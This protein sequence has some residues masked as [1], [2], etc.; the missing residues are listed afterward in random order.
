MKQAFKVECT[1]SFEFHSKL[2]CVCACEASERV[3]LVKSIKINPLTN[4]MVSSGMIAYTQRRTHWQI[5]ESVRACV[6]SI[7]W[8]ITKHNI[9]QRIA[10]V[11]RRFGDYMS[12][13][14]IIK[15]KLNIFPLIS[16]LC[17]HSVSECSNFYFLH[18]WIP[19]SHFRWHLDMWTPGV[20]VYF[21]VF[22]MEPNEI[23]FELWFKS[24]MMCMVLEWAAV[25]F[26]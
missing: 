17:G 24:P 5:K 19:H 3:K 4:F 2:V 11:L 15:K 22:H 8:L 16:S 6:W 9:N 14:V 18:D 1:H 25:N 26:W 13:I 12:I 23:P 21:Y 10:V 7:C 20:C